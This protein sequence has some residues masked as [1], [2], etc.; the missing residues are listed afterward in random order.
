MGDI[1]DRK[2]ITGTLF[3]LDR[4]PITW[5]SQKQRVVSISSCQAEY[6]A[7]STAACQAVWLGRL[8]GDLFATDPMVPTLL[9]DNKSAIQPSKN[10]VFHDRSKHIETRY[11]FIRENVESG[12][13]VVDYVNTDDQL[14]DILTKPLGR[15]KFQTLR[16][17]IG[18]VEI[19]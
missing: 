4:C 7:A 18:I 12:K 10:P 2:S 17:K 9:V 14:A 3:F 11:H 16:K 13:I 6:I 19:K 5:Q 15:T 1:D 8:I